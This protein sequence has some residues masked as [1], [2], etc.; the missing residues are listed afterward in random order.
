MAYQFPVTPTP[1]NSSV[2]GINAARA[3]AGTSTSAEPDR[4]QAISGE[5]WQ[6]T[7]TGTPDKERA[8]TT[9]PP[10][11]YIPEFP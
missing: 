1:D 7:A 3:F 8:A 5:N 4:A 2:A 6:R 10:A 9:F 11:E